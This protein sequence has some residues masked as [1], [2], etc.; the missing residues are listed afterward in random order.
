MQRECWISF[1]LDVKEYCYE[2]TSFTFLRN[3]LQVFT[4]NS[5]NCIRTTTLDEIIFSVTGNLTVS[6][7][8][9]ILLLINHLRILLKVYG[10]PNQKLCI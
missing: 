9:F 3:F 8:C 5:I 10:G 2:N 4:G 1:D 7:L 6:Y